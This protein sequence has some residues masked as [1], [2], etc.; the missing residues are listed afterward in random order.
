MAG[1]TNEVEPACSIQM[2]KLI[3]SAL[4]WGE[5]SKTSRCTVNFSN[6]DPAM[7]RFFT[8]VCQVPMGKFRGALHIH[9][10]LNA[11]RARRF[12]SSQSGIPL[13]QFHRTQIAVSR[14]STGKRD[15]LPMGTFRI[16][17]SDTKLQTKLRGWIN[18]MRR[19]VSGGE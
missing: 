15:T 12:W 5:G 7:M 2:L 3:G 10:H 9:P 18:G 4:Y 8:I 6:S 1:A 14:A 16:V 13:S 11:A 19:W 17:I